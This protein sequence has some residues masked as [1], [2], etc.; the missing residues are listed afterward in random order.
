[1]LRP[2]SEAPTLSALFALER[3]LNSLADVSKRLATGR[4]INSGKDDPA[5]LIAS[6]RLSAAL[7]SLEAESRALQRADSNA[8]IAEGH[9]AQLSSLFGDLNG[10]VVASANQ[11]GMTDGEIAAN[12]MQIDNTVASIQRIFGGAAGSLGGMSL[13]GTGNSDVAALYDDALTAALSVR[14][15]GANDLSSGSFEVAQT[16]LGAAL[17]DIAMARG[18]IGGYQKDA[19]GPQLRSNEIAYE[20]LTESR[21]RIAD[22][23]YAVEVS[24]LTRAQLL[25]D[26]SVAML[27]IVQRQP[28]TALSLLSLLNGR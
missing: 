28:R 20:N 10:L 24:N 6:E 16:A 17:T 18:R 19:V 4:R 7:E 22:A 12:Q 1:M 14:S 9:A 15:G 2:V 23:D 27:E 11:A 3:N 5:G 26:S 13:P 25:A 8:R 21:S